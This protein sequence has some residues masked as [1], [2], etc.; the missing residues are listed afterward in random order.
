VGIE[1]V[2]LQLVYDSSQLAVPGYA[3]VE[4]DSTGVATIVGVPKDQ[5]YRVQVLNVPVGA[6][7]THSN[8]G[9]DDVDSDLSRDDMSYN[10]DLRSFSGRAFDRLDL[11]Y[12]MPE[13]SKEK[14]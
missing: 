10:F 14:L 1:G 4:T 6:T 11:G 13:V 5:R 9:N 8:K 2:Q 7:R 12:I 3:P